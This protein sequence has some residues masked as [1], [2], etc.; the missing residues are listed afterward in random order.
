MILY[1]DTSSVAK[2]YIDEAGSDVVRTLVSQAAV[3]ATSP[4]E[5]GIPRR[6][7]TPPSRARVDGR[8][9]HATKRA[10]EA[11]W[12]S[13]VTVDVTSAL[14]RVAGAWPNATGCEATTAFTSPPT[15]R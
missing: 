10:F 6:A 7:R 3:V 8:G 2:L 12:P 5:P 13:Y 9:I 4:L 14:C 11:D 1:L 15:R